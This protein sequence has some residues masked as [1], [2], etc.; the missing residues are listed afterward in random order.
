MN[1]DLDSVCGCYYGIIAIGC[2]ALAVLI[3]LSV[4]KDRQR[5]QGQ[6]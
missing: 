6:G 3:G 2:I 1:I 4:R 5:Q